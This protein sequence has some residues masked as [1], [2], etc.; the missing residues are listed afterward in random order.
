M[1]VVCK[2]Q[3]SLSNHAGK[4]P[5]KHTLLPWKVAPRHTESFPELMWFRLLI[6]YLMQCG[7]KLQSCKCWKFALL[8]VVLVLVIKSTTSPNTSTDTHVSTAAAYA[9]FVIPD[10]PDIK[11]GIVMLVFREI[12]EIHFGA[13][14]AVNLHAQNLWQFPAISRVMAPKKMP[15]TCPNKG[16]HL[17]TRHVVTVH[18]PPPPCCPSD[19]P[20]QHFGWSSVQSTPFGH[21]CCSS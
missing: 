16:A 20:R 6:S 11:P 14:S 13:W 12:I 21:R 4:K 1:K 10:L 2:L 17:N 18:W 7:A 8:L 9:L 3:K 19:S 5:W 15:K